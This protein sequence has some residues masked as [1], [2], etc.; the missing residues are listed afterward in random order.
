MTKLGRKL[1]KIQKSINYIVSFINR[2][3]DYNIAKE[4]MQVG[5]DRHSGLDSRG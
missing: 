3:E 4:M 2:L 1:E 5:F